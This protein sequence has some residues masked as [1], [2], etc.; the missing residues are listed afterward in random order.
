MALNYTDLKFYYSM[1]NTGASGTSN[2]NN[3]L[4]GTIA[5]NTLPSNVLNAL[6]DMVTGEESQAGDTSYRCVY[7]KNEGSQ[8]AY[9]V[10]VSFDSNT[11]SSYTEVYIGADPAGV[12]DGQN[13]G[14]ATTIS[15]EHTAP[16]GVTFGT[17]DVVI[18][19]IPAGQ[20]A[21]VWFKWVVNAGTPAI[22]ED[23]IQI[24]INFET[25]Q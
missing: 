16:T 5:T 19:D 24:A 6:F 23:K 21:A 10:R 7:V 14:V 11:P 8:T 18:G 12:G 20:A 2:G 1:G 25:G 13:T 17:A 22:D 3:S 15:D 4:G 9:N